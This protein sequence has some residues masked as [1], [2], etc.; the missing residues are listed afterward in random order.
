MIINIRK[1][2]VKLKHIILF[3]TF[4]FCFLLFTTSC[5]DDQL[6]TPGAQTPSPING[7]WSYRLTSATLTNHFLF[8]TNRIT[9]GLSLLTNPSVTVREV[10]T[11]SDREIGFSW[12][13]NGQSI[14][15]PAISGTVRIYTSETYLN[16][17]YIL[18]ESSE[19]LYAFIQWPE[20]LTNSSISDVSL[21]FLDEISSKSSNAFLAERSYPSAMKITVGKG[22]SNDGS[23]GTNYISLLK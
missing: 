1:K 18:G 14:N 12:H 22:F 4:F 2:A 21:V 5:S 11:V 6:M 16:S 8:E 15:D 20:T 7:L 17:N 9:N 3:N 23:V 19:G 13:T 10:I